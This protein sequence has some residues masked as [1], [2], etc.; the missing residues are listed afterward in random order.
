MRF[1][2]LVTVMAALGPPLR[3]E[4]VVYRPPSGFRMTRFDLFESSRAG[5]VGSGGAVRGYLFAALTDGSGEDA[6]SLLL[7]VVESTFETGPLGRETLAVAT[8][9]HFVDLGQ[10]VEL[11]TAAVPAG[12]AGWVEVL[13]TIRQ[14]EQL[15]R[16]WVVAWPGEQRHVV[17]VASVPTS[18]WAQ[19]EPLLRESASSLVDE[20]RQGAGASRRLAW[21]GAVLG[22]IGLLGSWA[23]WRLRQQRRRQA[24]VEET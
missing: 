20:R 13:G 17:L 8:K 12:A 6:A 18:R 21:A 2:G 4:G 3:H 16:V 19:L 23:V 24:V 11:E 10:A 14:G 9:D 5:A 1:L 7:S 22:V 15:R